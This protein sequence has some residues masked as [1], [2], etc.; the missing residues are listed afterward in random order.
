MSRPDNW[1]A[2]ELREW[3]KGNLKIDLQKEFKEKN[4]DLIK[5]YGKD[6]FT[7]K[8]ETYDAAHNFW[9]Q[10]EARFAH[11]YPATAWL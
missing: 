2:K 5:E 10:N 11:G 4:K 6:R 7:Y 8:A 9:Y 1:R 3:E